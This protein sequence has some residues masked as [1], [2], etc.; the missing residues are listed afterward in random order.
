[1]KTKIIVQLNFHIKW[2]SSNAMLYVRMV[3]KHVSSYN[4][5]KF[6]SSNR[7]LKDFSNCNIT[8]SHGVGF[9]MV[10]INLTSMWSKCGPKFDFKHSVQTEV[11][12]YHHF[13][14]VYVYYWT[15]IPIHW[16]N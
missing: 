15:D 16:A 3:R 1:M 2:A 10:D 8:L 4:C 7:T 12:K 9:S 11:A 6:D 14:L 5:I 13:E